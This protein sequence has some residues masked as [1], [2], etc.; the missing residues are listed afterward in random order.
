MPPVRPTIVWHDRATPAALANDARTA[1]PA[2]G[3]LGRISESQIPPS[4]SAPPAASPGGRERDRLNQLIIDLSRELYATGAYSDAPLRELMVIAAMS[5]VDSNRKIDPNA[6]PDLTEKERELLGG[7]QT[8]FGALHDGFEN[9]A[10]L[11]Q[12][13]IDAS[14]KLRQS[15]A[16]EPQLTLATAALCTRVGGFGDYSTFEKNTF[17]AANDQK[18]I[19]YLEIDEFT[20]EL[21]GNNEFVTELAQQLAIYSDRDGIP[22]WKEDWQSAVDVTRNRRQDFFTVQVI[23]LPKALSVGRYHLKIRIRDEKSGAE[24]EGSIPFELVADPRMTTGK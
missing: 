11:E 24:A 7:L 12:T 16:K 14:A 20:S 10:D 18:V 17:L 5:I 4:T 15:L 8:F 9:Q 23:T 19:V 6:V 22:V 13:I 1:E 21:N 3:A 2:Q